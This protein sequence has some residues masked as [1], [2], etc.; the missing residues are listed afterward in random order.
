MSALRF[1][2][3]TRSICIAV[4]AL[5]P[6]FSTSCGSSNNNAISN[7]QAQAISQELVTAVGSAVTGQFYGGGPGAAHA[8]LSKIIREARP[9]TSSGCTPT[10]NGETCNF[11]I[12]YTGPCPSGGTISVSGDFN[13]TLN[14]SGTGSDS[15]TLTITPTNCVVSNLTINGDPSVTLSTTLG[16]TNDV[17]NFPVNMNESGGISYGPH[18]SGSCSVNVSLTLQQNSC[19]VSGMVCGHSVNGNCPAVVF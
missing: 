3:L 6:L 15:N 12:S 9:E 5:V 11:P 19:S 10:S 2:A 8:S 13:L 4:V 14:G 1:S 16:Y 18:P 7:A 17:F